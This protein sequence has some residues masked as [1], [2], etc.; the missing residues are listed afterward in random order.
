[1]VVSFSVVGFGAGLAGLYLRRTRPLEI[2]TT[3]SAVKGVGRGHGYPIVL[4]QNAPV[5]PAV[6][7]T[8]TI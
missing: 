7:T 2:D 8:A 6:D 3:G 5:R 1:M 4:A